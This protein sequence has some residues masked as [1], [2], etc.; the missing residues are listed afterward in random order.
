MLSIK[1]K[2]FFFLMPN[3]FTTAELVKNVKF[4]KRLQYN[5]PLQ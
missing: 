4:L 3:T 2:L 5:Y 1:K